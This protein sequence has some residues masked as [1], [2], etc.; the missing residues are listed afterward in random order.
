MRPCR[1]QGHEAHDDLLPAPGVKDEHIE[2]AERKLTKVPA[3]HGN[4]DMAFRPIG[5][6]LDLLRQVYVLSGIFVVTF[7]LYP[8]LATCFMLRNHRG[9][10]L[11]PHVFHRTMSRLLGLNVLVRSSPSSL[12]PLVLASNHT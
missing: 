2:K 7:A 9:Q 3:R 4:P 5:R 12:R 11:V 8:W 10:Q 6:V 1:Q